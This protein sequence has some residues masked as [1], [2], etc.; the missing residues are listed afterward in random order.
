MGNPKKKKKTISDKKGGGSLRT[1]PFLPILSII[2]QV[3]GLAFIAMTIL[4]ALVFVYFAKDLPR[5]EKFTESPFSQSAQIFD[6]TGKV[7]LYT[8]YGEE[9]RKIV[10]LSQ[11]PLFVQEAVIATEDKNFYHHIGVDLTSVVR[12][13]LAD[14]RTGQ[15]G[16]GGSTIT[17]QLIRS[18]FLTND[19]LISRKVKEWVLTLEMERRY[20]KKQILEFY[21][22]QIPFGS[23]SYGV[24]TASQTFFNKH[25]SELS[26]EE[27]AVLV[28]MIKSPSGLSPYG[29]R[30][31]DLLAR[32]D[33]VIDRMVKE[34]YLSKNDGDNY[35]SKEIIFV[36]LIQRIY[37]PHFVMYVKDILEKKYGEEYIREKGL[38]IITS[39]DWEIQEWAEKAVKDG[40]TKNEAVHAYNA[41]MVA[42]DPKTGEILAMVGSKDYFADPQPK[43]CNPGVNCLFEPNPNVAIR[44]RQP[45]SSFKPFVYATAFVNGYHDY[46]IT[47]DEETNFGTASNP[48]IPQNYDGLF[49][50]PVT[51]RNALAQ[52]LN[53]PAVKVLRDFAGLKASIQTAKNFG[54]TTLTRPASFYGLPLVLGGG[55][56]K[57]LEMATAYGV[58]AT[59]GLYIPSTPILRIEDSN[60]VIIE[61]NEKTPKK[62]LN[63]EVADTINSI[64]SDNNARAPIF[65]TH[66]IL[67]FDRYQVAAKT[68]TTQG[69]RDGWVIGYTPNLVVGVW[70]GNNNNESMKKEP[71]ISVAGPIWRSFIDKTLPLFPEENF[72]PPTP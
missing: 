26:V 67:Y 18:T 9:K 42:I 25:I 31:N 49:R 44:N 56:V 7:L 14:I 64:L 22:N 46:T 68:G 17:Q 58:F 4:G 6:R 39:I 10:P 5:P 59:R 23:N 1:K 71:G 15:A 32:K 51:L 29:P 28:S 47:I 52:S 70:A 38:R 66:S 34:K 60:G 72:A 55:E 57:L 43:G 37:A 41:S 8:I 50:G 21:L 35:K 53:V 36:P 2:L 62:V 20:D 63:S 69:Y 19:K 40:A 27:G 3:V 16:Q 65:G 54:I 61:R 33:Y 13:I 12:A 45:G 48:Y 11:I 24:E 30:L